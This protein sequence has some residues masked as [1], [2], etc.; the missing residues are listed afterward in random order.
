[1]QILGTKTIGLSLQPENIEKID[2]VRGLAGRSTVVDIVLSYLPDDSIKS[3]IS[4]VPRIKKKTQISIEQYEKE[5]QVE[6]PQIEQISEKPQ[7]DYGIG[8]SDTSFTVSE[9]LIQ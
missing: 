3:I 6:K 4:S 2:R 9:P 1:M 7:K 5:K 8:S